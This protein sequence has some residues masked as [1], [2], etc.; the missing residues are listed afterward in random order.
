MDIERK[1]TDSEKEDL[2]D[3]F[4]RMGANGFKRIASYSEWLVMQKEHLEKDLERS[5]YTDDLYKQ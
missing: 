1:L 3:V 2:F 5:H 4:Y